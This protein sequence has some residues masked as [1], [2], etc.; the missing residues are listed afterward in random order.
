MVEKVK[1]KPIS[2]MPNFIDNCKRFYMYVVI[3][4]TWAETDG[5]M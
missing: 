1:N 3:K 4:L 2:R 5:W